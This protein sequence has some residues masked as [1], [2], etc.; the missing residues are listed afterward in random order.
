M[1]VLECYPGDVCHPGGLQLQTEDIIM[2]I[3]DTS[4]VTHFVCFGSLDEQPKIQ[5]R[6]N[7]RHSLFVVYN[8]KIHTDYYL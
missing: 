5:S 3:V 2:T 7:D 1:G 8:N 4:A 6:L